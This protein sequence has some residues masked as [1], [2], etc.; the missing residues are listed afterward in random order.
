MMPFAWL[1]NHGSEYRAAILTVIFLVIVI[2]RFPR[3]TRNLGDH[4]RG[5]GPF[6]TP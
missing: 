3:I 1:A 2:H 6:A 4:F 5:G